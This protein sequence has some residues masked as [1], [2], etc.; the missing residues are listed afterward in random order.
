M[1]RFQISR[2]AGTVKTWLFRSRRLGAVATSFFLVVA[3]SALVIAQPA[4]AS[5]PS[6]WLSPTLI[7]G[8]EGLSSVSCTS[9]TFCM[10]VDSG[11]DALRYNGSTWSSPSAIVSGEGLTSVSC[12]ST[13]SA[14]CIAVDYHGNVLS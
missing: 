14:F 13:S 6:T 9:T 7:D 8:G 5:T 10:A 11:G 4:S 12:T 2:L 1:N 3:S